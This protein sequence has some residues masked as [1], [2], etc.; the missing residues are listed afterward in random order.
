MF[1]DIVKQLSLE[2]YWNF[3]IYYTVIHKLKIESTGKK[4]FNYY[5]IIV[6]IEVI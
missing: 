4:R 3:N 6:T 1:V 5:I 2:L